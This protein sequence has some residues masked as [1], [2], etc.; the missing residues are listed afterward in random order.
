MII[1]AALLLPVLEGFDQLLLSF[2]LH[3][4]LA[5]SKQCKQ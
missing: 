1:F 5:R 4:S 2:S 3:C